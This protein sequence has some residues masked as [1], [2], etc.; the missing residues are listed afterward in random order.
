[1]FIEGSDEGDEES[2]G[3]FNEV[4]ECLGAGVIADTAKDSYMVKNIVGQ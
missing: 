2:K 4:S 3:D 1:M